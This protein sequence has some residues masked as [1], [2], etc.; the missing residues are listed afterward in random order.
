MTPSQRFLSKRTCFKKSYGNKN[1]NSGP[2]HT[3]KLQQIKCGSFMSRREKLKAQQSQ[4]Y[5]ARVHLSVRK[6]RAKLKC[7]KIQRVVKFTFSES[8]VFGL[9]Y[10]VS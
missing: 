10:C 8:S 6:R 1:F 4:Q 2:N 5:I 7:L 3:D 9:Q